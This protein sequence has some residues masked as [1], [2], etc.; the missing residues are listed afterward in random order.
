MC[1]K[2]SSDFHVHLKKKKTSVVKAS[3]NIAVL[4]VG[5]IDF[6]N[7]MLQLLKFKKLNN[8]RTVIIVLIA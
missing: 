5:V 4:S 3:F 7:L 2:S 6:K 8:I 1:V